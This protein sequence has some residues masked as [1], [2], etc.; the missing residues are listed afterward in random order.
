MRKDQSKRNKTQKKKNSVGVVPAGFVL[1]A[2]WEYL[3]R[4]Q[5]LPWSLHKNVQFSEGRRQ[6]C[7]AS[8][9]S[10]ATYGQPHCGEL[11]VVYNRKQQG[12]LSRIFWAII[13]GW[14][15]LF[16]RSQRRNAARQA[17]FF[18]AA[19]LTRI[20]HGKVTHGFEQV[21]RLT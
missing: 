21:T 8:I 17:F 14:L 11:S 1:L 18:G 15:L 3:K 12:S 6:A 20:V 4:A 5:S 13:A 19:E 16:F 7:L 2:V 9:A 10:K